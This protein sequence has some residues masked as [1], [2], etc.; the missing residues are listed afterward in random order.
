[1]TVSVRGWDVAKRGNFEPIISEK[2]FE[3][4]QALLSGKKVTNIPRKRYNPDF[5]LRHFV[6]CGSCDKPLTGSWSKG[7]KSK[8][9]Y[10]HCQNKECQHKVNVRG[11]KME[12]QFVEFLNHLRPRKEFLD[13]FRA[14]ILD[15]WNGKQL[16][17]KE[18]RAA[19]EKKVKGLQD[20]KQALNAAFVYERAIERPD[21]EQMK[22]QLEAELFTAEVQ[23]HEARENEL[24]ME[25]VISFAEQV[26][27]DAPQMWQL[28]S[29]DQKQRFQQVLFPEGVQFSGGVY[30]T[31][32]TC[33][34]FNGIATEIPAKEEL[35]ALAG[36]EPA[37][38]P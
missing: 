18:I 4:V 15:V 8:Y 20:R 25:S 24:D 9:P 5:P 10:Y 32:T 3:L 36:I 33:L 30:R 27:L 7:R 16:D 21:Y 2:T 35:V 12:Q 14:V 29:P 28:M 37:F 38:W 17:A 11:E 19:L 13:L 22:G 26:F 23:L 34:A 31:A 6:R 1:V